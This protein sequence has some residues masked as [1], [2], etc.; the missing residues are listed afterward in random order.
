[1]KNCVETITWGNVS[2]VGFV[3]VD[4]KRK[5]F[6]EFFWMDN[7]VGWLARTSLNQRIQ[8]GVNVLYLRAGRANFS[9]L[10]ENNIFIKMRDL[11]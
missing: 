9:A 6:V 5:L 8:C 2:R 4:E 10:F 7:F 11:Q 1:M 3:L